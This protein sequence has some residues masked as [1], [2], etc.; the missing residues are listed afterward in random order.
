[1]GKLAR[2]GES[3]LGTRFARAIQRICDSIQLVGGE[4][5]EP[6]PPCGQGILS[7]SCLPFHHPPIQIQKMEAAQ[8]FEPWITDLQSAALVHLAMPPHMMITS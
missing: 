7:P 2:R 1:M 6:S 8:G 3:A 5:V 4:G